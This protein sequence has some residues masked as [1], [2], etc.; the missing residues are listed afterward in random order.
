MQ[1][2]AGFDRGLLEGIARYVRLHGPWLFCLSAYN[3]GIPMPDSDSI[4]AELLHTIP[5]SKAS[6]STSLPLQRLGATGVI[7]RIQTPAITRTLLASGLPI[8]AVEL[9]TSQLADRRL[10]HRV[11]QI[12]SDSHRAGRI[13][14]EHLLDCGLTSLAF[15][16]YRGRNWS[17]RRQEGFCERLREAG[18]SYEVYQSPRGRALPW[19]REQPRV[20]AWVRS[21]TKPVGIMACND[22]RGWQLI[23]ACI[24]AGL[25]VPD[26]VAVVGVDEDQLLCEMASPPLSSVALNLE[27]AGYQAAELLDGL[28]TGRIKQPRQINIDAMFVTPRRST[29]IL[30]VEDRHVAA[31]ARFVRDHFRQAITVDD[32]V[33]QAGCSRRGLEIRFQR[34]LGRSIRQEIQRARLAWS[35]RLATETNLSVEKI[36]AAAGFS[37][38]S[39]LSQVFRRELGMTLSEYRRQSHLS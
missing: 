37:G 34:C 11:S 32:V 7:G 17:E 2:F 22:N 35:K 5:V 1:P 25:R 31:A 30:A 29:D 12:R 27:R 3:P 10:V 33:A 38:L 6:R 28:M 23:E 9:T 13:A 8:V 19:H 26:D 18:L 21:L 39:Y 16:G 4:G 14:A 15:C 24:Q 36:A 20:I